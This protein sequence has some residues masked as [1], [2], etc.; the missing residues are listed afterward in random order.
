M[1]RYENLASFGLLFIAVLLIYSNTYQASWHLDDYPNIVS[2]PRLH[3]KDLSPGSLISTFRASI[4]GGRYQGLSVYRPVACLT[5]ALNWYFHEDQVAGYHL[6]NNLLHFSAAFLLFLT[7]MALL[8]SPEADLKLQDRRFFIALLTAL[9]WAINPIQT[10]AVTYIVQRMAALSTL[11]YLTSLYFFVRARI[12]P[13]EIKRGLLYSA[14][15]ISF[16]FAMGSKENSVTLPAA[17]VMAEV[18]FFSKAGAVWKRTAAWGGRCM[19]ALGTAAVL[20]YFTDKDFF[21]IFEGYADRPFTMLQRL[22]T[23]SSVLLYYLTLIFYP[24]P[25]RLSIVHEVQISSSLFTPWTTL[26]AIL[27]VL[28][29]ILFGFSQIKKRPLWAFAILFYFLNHLTESSIVPLELVFEHR[30]HLPSLFLFLPVAAGIARAMDHYALTSPRMHLTMRFAL[31]LLIIA[32]GSGTYVRNMFWATEKSLWED[33]MEKAPQSARPLQ[34]LALHHYEKTGQ[35]DKA[36]ELYQKSLPLY[37]PN[38]AYSRAVALVN[39]GGIYYRKNEFEKTVALC[40][41]AEDIYPE[42]ENARYGRVLALVRLGRLDE[43]L[44]G[45]DFLLSKQ[46]SHPG[47]LHVK[48]LILLKQ[49]NPEAATAYLKPTPD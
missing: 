39:M 47:Y 35:I 42:Y 48:R 15:A 12:E 4:D 36:L 41:Q 28:F 8:K 11:F 5:F 13:A 17:L 27:L 19:L 30:N 9:L 6:V 10:Q 34:S 38:P 49:K 14:C 24:A 1:R 16:A 31:G 40:K 44:R 46:K 20:L 29:L 18:L 43:A 21:G 3:I 37:D 32:L 45:I 23:E 7:V 25:Q 33:A 2:N 26:P 22:M